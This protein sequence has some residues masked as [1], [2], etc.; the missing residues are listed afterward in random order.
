MEEQV[1]RLAGSKAM[2]VSR[3]DWDDHLDHELSQLLWLHREMQS[4]DYRSRYDRRV[5]RAMD[6]AFAAHFRALL[7]FF[8]NGRARSTR[9]R[10]L[11]LMHVAPS[12]QPFAW[13]Q[14]GQPRLQDADRLVG[15]IC[16]E[17]PGQTSDWDSPEDWALVRPMIERLFQ[18]L[19]DAR[20]LLP[21]AS[22]QWDQL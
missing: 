20:K 3:P 9:G 11:H 2:T 4:P 6:V 5:R 12:A 16:Q 7:E 21:M 1:R 22:E 14:Y 10:D 19:T 15:H 18:S 17:R 8:H 13:T